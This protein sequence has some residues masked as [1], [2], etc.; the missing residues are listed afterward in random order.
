MK[1]FVVGL[2]AGALI[3]FSAQVYSGSSNLVG[4][5]VSGTM[6]VNLNK[7]AMG[8]A[9]V[10]EGKSYLPVRSMAEGMNLNV[11]VQSKTINLTNN[12]LSEEDRAALEESA[13][14]AQEEQDKANTEA[15]KVNVIISK[16][17]DIK[18]TQGLIEKNKKNIVKYETMLAEMKQ[19]GSDIYVYTS[20]EGFPT[21]FN[22]ESIAWTKSEI[23]RLKK[24][25][26]DFAAKI[27]HLEAEIAEL[28]K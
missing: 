13:K 6:D 24:E 27:K 15:E 18:Y 7:K 8:Q 10:I 26:E 1:K 16:K 23:E 14:R 28:E 5:K 25:N 4:T 9:V 22:S 2:F 17:N 19:T 21:A 11:D 20:P 12:G 3:M